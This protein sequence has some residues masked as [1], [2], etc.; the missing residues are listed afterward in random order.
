MWPFA[1]V[2]HANHQGKEKNLNL[3]LTRQIYRVIPPKNYRGDKWN[4][5]P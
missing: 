3:S 1:A 5:V 2:C 4:S